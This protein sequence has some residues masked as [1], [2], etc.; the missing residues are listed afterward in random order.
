MNPGEETMY[1]R[2]F[3]VVPGAGGRHEGAEQSDLPVWKVE[4]QDLPMDLRM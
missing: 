1:V 4:P 3:Q 2:L